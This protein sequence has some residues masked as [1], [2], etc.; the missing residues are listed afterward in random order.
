MTFEVNDNGQLV[1]SPED[2]FEKRLLAL[3]YDAIPNEHQGTRVAINKD[4]CI[5]EVR[6]R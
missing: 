6:N 4:R 2:R 5:L 3:F 1:V